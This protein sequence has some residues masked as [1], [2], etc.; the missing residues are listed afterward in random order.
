MKCKKNKWGLLCVGIFLGIAF[1]GW[2]I[3]SANSAPSVNAK[4]ASIIGYGTIEAIDL[5]KHQIMIKHDAIKAIDWSAMTMPFT[6]AEKLDISQWK[7]GDK[8]K[9][10]LDKDKTNQIIQIEKADK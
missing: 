10:Q 8:I 1:A 6:A 4:P 9:F 3:G 2:N 5:K 7:V